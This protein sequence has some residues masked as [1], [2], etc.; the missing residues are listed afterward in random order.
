MGLLSGRLFD[1]IVIAALNDKRVG[2][3]TMEQIQNATVN[4]L[5]EFPSLT[6]DE[7][8]AQGLIGGES[9]KDTFFVAKCSD[10]EFVLSVGDDGTSLTR[11]SP[12]STELTPNNYFEAGRFT[13]FTEQTAPLSDTRYPIMFGNGGSDDLG[14]ITFDAAGTL[15]VNKA[16]PIG[17]KQRM[18]ITRTGSNGV[19][20]V[21]IQAQISVDGGSNWVAIGDT[22]HEQIDESRD[23]DIFLDI[24]FLELIPGLKFRATWAVDGSGVNDAE[25]VVFTPTA[26]LLADGFTEV[27][28]TETVIY[29]LR[30][31]D[32]Q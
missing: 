27:G 17:I 11:L 15:T 6:I 30:G 9:L 21:L 8:L 2:S 4:S 28:S 1:Q 29:A 3:L 20:H 25:M 10:G 19:C 32:Y 7:L 18:R 26:A 14:I 24:S 16:G 23:T 5:I 12:N 22:Q 31:Y 13:D